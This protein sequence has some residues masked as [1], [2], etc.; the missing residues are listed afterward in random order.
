M[1]P[2]ALASF[3]LMTVPPLNVLANFCR[4]V[5][6][7]EFAAGA[8]PAGAAPATAA[9]AVPVP[10]DVF[11]AAGALDAAADAA[12]AGLRL[13]APEAGWHGPGTTPGVF[14]DGAADVCV[15]AP[16]K[17][18]A[19]DCALAPGDLPEAADVDDVPAVANAPSAFM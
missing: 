16:D 7:D 11:P 6:S 1:L 10:E 8:P 3:W 12:V 19:D 13:P 9:S 17:G 2:A 14:A 18:A 15:P 5:L 4:A